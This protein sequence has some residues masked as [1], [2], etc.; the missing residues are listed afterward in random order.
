[1]SESNPKILI[2]SDVHL[3]AL[4]SNLE[5]FSLFLNKIMNGEFGD[6][7]KA[8]LILGDFIDLCTSVK[9]SFLA[10]KKLVSIFNQLLEIKK[11]IHIVFIFE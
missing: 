11:K 10:D 5:Q 7:I 6:D 2:V 4:K 3:G 9:K 8:L 1:M